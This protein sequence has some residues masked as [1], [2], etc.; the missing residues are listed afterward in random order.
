MSV[1]YFIVSYTRGGGVSICHN[2]IALIT[3]PIHALELCNI[4]GMKGFTP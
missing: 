1:V 2:N 3:P 4:Y